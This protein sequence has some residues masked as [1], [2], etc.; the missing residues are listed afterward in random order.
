ME[1]K[2]LTVPGALILGVGLMYLLARLFARRE[3]SDTVT[4]FDLDA[5]NYAWLR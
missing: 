5:P 2:N 1:A 3:R 4:A